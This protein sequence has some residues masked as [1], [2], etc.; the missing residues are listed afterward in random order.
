LLP[1][2]CFHLLHN[3]VLI[4]LIG[5]PSLVRDAGPW[6]IG[7][8]LAIAAGVVWWLYRK[9]YVDLARREADGIGDELR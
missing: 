4:G 5:M 7:G 6:L 2:I 3:T 1:A 9:P 8:S